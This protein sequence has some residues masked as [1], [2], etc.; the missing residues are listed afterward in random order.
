MAAGCKMRGRKSAQAAWRDPCR[1]G[2]TRGMGLAGDGFG[3]SGVDALGVEER[4]ISRYWSRCCGRAKGARDGPKR[5]C[6]DD[7][8]PQVVEICRRR[9]SHVV[10]V[11]SMTVLPSERGE[12]LR[13]S[14]R[15]LL[16][17][18]QGCRK[19]MTVGEETLGDGAHVLWGHF[20][21][22]CHRYAPIF[23]RYR[24]SAWP[25]V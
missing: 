9:D 20:G 15:V 11:P 16:R 3:E 22:R 23:R 19:I 14:S 6:G 24:N 10:G 18:G 2:A 4:W 7:E 21:L 1:P 8:R 25:E 17:R 5:T 13:S 12:G